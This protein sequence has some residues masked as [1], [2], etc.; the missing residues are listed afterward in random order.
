MYE[1]AVERRARP[2]AI[3]RHPLYA[4]FLPV[5]IVCFI[6]ALITDLSYLNS[7]GNLL[8]LN[9]SSW[10]LA[11]G[12]LFGAIAGLF[13][14]IDVIRGVRGLGLWGFLLLL[15][16]WIVELINSFVHAR[17]GWTAVAGT[18]L[19]LSIVGVVLVLIAGW[20]W[21]SALEVRP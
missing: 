19:I 10:L 18:G 16:A 20:L 8:W 14:L 15:A 2:I 21:R 3:A 1:T 11:A 5:P 4:L 6:G 17:D 9:F 7:G 13:L 12:L